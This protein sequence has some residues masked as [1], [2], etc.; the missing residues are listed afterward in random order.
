MLL[1]CLLSK[2]CVYHGFGG[3]WLW[4]GLAIRGTNSRAFPTNP[5]WCQKVCFPGFTRCWSRCGPLCCV[6]LS[7]V[8][9]FSMPAHG[10]AN[11]Q[12]GNIGPREM[13]H[14]QS[15]SCTGY[16]QP[17]TNIHNQLQSATRKTGGGGLLVV[18]CCW[19]LASFAG[20][21]WL[22]LPDTAVGRHRLCRRDTSANPTTHPPH[23]HQTHMKHILNILLQTRDCPKVDVRA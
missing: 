16:Y 11:L 18:V 10:H 22:R 4:L 5:D 6:M 15:K 23:P 2:K 13:P 14:S 3:S 12:M 19:W 17:P 1:V 21:L 8:C 9:H 20:T 7:A